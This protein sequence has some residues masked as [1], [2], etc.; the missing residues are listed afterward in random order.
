VRA[1]GVEERQPDPPGVVLALPGVPLDLFEVGSATAETFLDHVAER[2]ARGFTGRADDTALGLLRHVL[3]LLQDR[4]LEP[5]NPFHGDAGGF[6]DLLR[7][8]ACPDSGLDL[9]G[10]QRT[11]HFDL[12]LAEAGEM[13]TDC[14]SEPVVHRQGEPGAP[15][16]GGQHE[17]RTVLAHRDEA[18]LLH[19]CPFQPI[20]AVS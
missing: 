19:A 7:G 18:Q 8:L 3:A 14:R 5:A 10:S 9:L 11:L 17:V 13:P 1:A 2:R 16:G 20:P 6:R 15:A 12:E 4:A